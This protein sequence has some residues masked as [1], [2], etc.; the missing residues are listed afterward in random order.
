MPITIPFKASAWKTGNATVVTI[1]GHIVKLLKL[2]PRDQIHLE[3]K[4]HEKLVKMKPEF[5]KTSRSIEIRLTQPS[6]LKYNL[7]YTREELRSFFPG[8]KE[9]FLLDTDVGIFQT[10]ITSAPKGT[11]TGDLVAGSY[12][13]K[14]LKKW[15]EA[16]PEIRH[17]S[18]VRISRLRQTRS[19]KMRKYKLEIID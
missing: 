3:I 9:P 17:G 19:A 18:K 2:E 8:Y 4:E 11:Q 6:T 14:N 5:R 16:H 13:H 10:W 12:F 1:P 7:I 15:F